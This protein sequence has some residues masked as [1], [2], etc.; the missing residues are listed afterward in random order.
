MLLTAP[1][2]GRC[3]RDQTRQNGRRLGRAT[4]PGPAW[5]RRRPTHA[6]RREWQALALADSS[7]LGGCGQRHVCRWQALAQRYCRPGWSPCSG[8][9]ATDCPAGSTGPA[10]KATPTQHGRGPEVRVAAYSCAKPAPSATNRKGSPR[11]LKPA[12]IPTTPLLGRP[13]PDFLST[14]ALPRPP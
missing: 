2:C 13:P 7:T 9:T 1:L 14:G 4:D 5:P 12:S 11:A 8:P 6:P 3:A 10:P